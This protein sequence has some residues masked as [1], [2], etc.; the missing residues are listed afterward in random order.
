MNNAPVLR[1]RDYFFTWLP[2]AISNAVCCGVAGAV[3]GA[4]AGIVLTLSGISPQSNHKLFVA[5]TGGAGFV[6]S[7]PISYLLFRLFVSHLWQTR[8]TAQNPSA[9]GH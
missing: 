3:A 7:L 1:E 4:I 9:S 6:A 2:F 8:H 5:I